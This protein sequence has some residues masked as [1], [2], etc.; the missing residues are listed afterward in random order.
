MLA[1][2]RSI[3]LQGIDAYEVII[4]SDITETIPSFT[5][6]GLPDGAVKESRERV[7]SAIKNSGFDFPARKVTINMAPADI[8]KEGSAYDLPIALG[9][10]ISTRQISNK[11]QDFCIIGE[12]ALDGTLRPIKGVLPIAL[13]ARKNG[14]SAI[15]VP[16][17]NADEAAVAQGLPVYPAKTLKDAIDLVE[18]N[19]TIEAKTC[20]IDKIFSKSQDFLLDFIDVKGQSVVKKALL[21]A[22]CGGHN[23]LM[24]GPPGSGKTMIAKRIPSILPPLTLDESLETTI[25]HSIAGKLPPKEPLVI[26]RPFRSPHHNISDAGLI[27]GGTYPKPGE[28]SLSHHGVLF[29][30]ELPEFDKNVLENLR[31]PLENKSVTISRAALSLSFPADFMLIAAM[32]PCPCGHFGDPAHKCS[33]TAQKIQNYIGKLSGPLLDRIDIQIRVSSLPYEDL[34]KKKGTES[35]AEMREKVIKAREI[36]QNRFKGNKGIF[37]NANMESKDLREFCVLEEGC[38]E[39]L[40]SAIDRLGLSARAY[41]RILKVS[42]TIADLKGN[43]LIS[44]P[45]IAEAVQYRTLD[46]NL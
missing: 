8:R 9:I 40:K 24:I 10:L 7:M 11:N 29:L 30:D 12:L 4:E 16:E 34:V 39:M 3:A 42:R 2:L 26:N 41:D 44:K 17:K 22:A 25:I 35:S 46:R 45:D 43:A 18:G 23:M 14:F 1:R 32:N 15:I 31:Q 36:Q 6:V 20:D 27:G 28:I 19:S 38:G 13:C 33:C 37:C 21:V 5:I